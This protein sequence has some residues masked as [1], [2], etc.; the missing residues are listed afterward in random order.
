MK[1]SEERQI[2]LAH[3]II[4]GVWKDDL[5]DFTDDDLAM[6]VAKRQIAEWVAEEDNIDQL[7]RGKIASL[8]R[9][10]IESTPEWDVMYSKYYQEET[11]KRGDN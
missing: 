11:R 10:I 6:R 1:L 4:D 8:K 9:S 2:H 7:V 5:V 3:V